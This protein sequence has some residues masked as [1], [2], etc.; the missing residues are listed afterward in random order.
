MT[1]AQKLPVC[2][3][4]G[5]QDHWL[6]DHLAEVHGL[7]IEQAV[8]QY[9]DLVIESPALTERVETQNSRVRRTAAPSLKDLT[10]QYGRFRFKVNYDVPEEDCLPMPEAYVL[11]KNGD[12]AKDCERAL[13]YLYSGRSTYI[14]GLPG[15]GKDA[16]VH[17]LCASARTPSAI[18]QIHPDVDIMS[19]LYTRSFDKD[20]TGWEEGT[21]LKQLRDGYTTSTGRKLPYLILLS[22][23]DRA[24]RAQAE[25]IR[26]IT[27]SI[28][29][30]LTGPTGETFQVFPGTQ[31]VA[32]ANTMGGGDDRGRMVSSNVIDG[33]ILDRFGRKVQFHMMDWKD[34]EKIVRQKFPL[35]VSKCESLLS[36][37]HRCV[38]A[39]RKAVEDNE[40]YGE[41]SHRGLSAWLEDAEDILRISPKVPETLL[42][43]A[44]MAVCDGFPDSEARLAAQRL[45]DPHLS[46]GTLKHGNTSG[47]GDNLDL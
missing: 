33:S 30:R 12:L 10:V 22:D 18:Y 9:P 27:D 8:D 29:G 34:E 20:S 3:I 16:L 4:C 36:N 28:Q 26:L 45:V 15:T 32:T 6:G 1:A 40:L 44:F 19:W 11:P 2:P 39:L 41:F 21:L 24:T 47:V 31:I 13:R 7:S 38:V 46:G 14:Y 5:H 25:T 17:A 42:S 23:F 43:Q 37:V 35:F